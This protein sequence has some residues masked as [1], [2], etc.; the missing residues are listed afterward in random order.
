MKNPILAQISCLE[1]MLKGS[2]GTLTP[3]QKEILEI[4]VESS[5][6]MKDLL[7]SILKSYKYDNGALKLEYRD[8]N[9]DTLINKCMNE[10]IGLASEKNIEL[11]YK[12]TLTEEEK[13]IIA[14]KKHIRTIIS[15]MINNG[16][17][18]GFS[19]TDYVITTFKKDNNIAFSFENS[20]PEIP[21]EIKNHIFDKY[22][23]G[24][25]KYH[26][27]G[28]GLGLYISKKIVDEHKGKIYLT[29]EGTRNKFTVEIPFRP[30]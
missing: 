17:S 13:E 4:T 3:E 12:S 6:Y 7:Y 11:V 19:G 27:I 14:D 2:F 8:F 20:S 10:A 5:K 30:E 23:T 24:A 9:V 22:V 1:M 29:T 26:K 18:Y 28:F 15:N 25:S 21:E 16:L